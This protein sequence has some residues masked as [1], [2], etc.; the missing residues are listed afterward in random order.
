M[1]SDFTPDSFSLHLLPARPK[2]SSHARGFNALSLEPKHDTVQ[3][4]TSAQAWRELEEHIAIMYNTLIYPAG[5]YG[6]LLGP[7]Q[8]LFLTLIIVLEHHR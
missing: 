2:I 8:L 3:I 4:F 1:P 7:A 6:I 5:L